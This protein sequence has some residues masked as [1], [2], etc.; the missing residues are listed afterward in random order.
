MQFSEQVPK[1][2]A[3]HYGCLVKDEATHEL[4]H[5][6]EKPETFVSDLI[7]SGVNGRL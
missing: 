2:Y 7:N 6:T 4:L 1:E 3:T 5:Y